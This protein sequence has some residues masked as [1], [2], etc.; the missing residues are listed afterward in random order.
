[1]TAN[2][3]TSDP[4]PL[5]PTNG[6]RPIVE[7]NG[8]LND[9]FIDHVSAPDRILT[10]PELCSW[11]LKVLVKMVTDNPSTPPSAS[12]ST[13]PTGKNMILQ[14][15]TEACIRGLLA[16]EKA[17]NTQNWPTVKRLFGFLDARLWEKQAQSANWREAYPGLYDSRCGAAYVPAFYNDSNLIMVSH[18]AGIRTPT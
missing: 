13:N 14:L 17:K 3:T 2:P 7:S 10:D 9:R 15:D 12:P 1:M 16:L 11:W 8:Y 5:P 6:F 18:Y 4:S